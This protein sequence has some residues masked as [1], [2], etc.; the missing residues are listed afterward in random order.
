VEHTR[1]LLLLKPPFGDFY[2]LRLRL[3]WGMMH[4]KM[5]ALPSTSRMLTAGFSPVD[6]KTT[7]S[8]EN[9]FQ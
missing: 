4:A 6:E 9:A 1:G 7:Q 5:C 2:N 3:L 8:G